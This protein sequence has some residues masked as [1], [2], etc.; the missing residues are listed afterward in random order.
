MCDYE[1]ARAARGPITYSR[2]IYIAL[3]YAMLEE[4]LE[5]GECGDW[6]YDTIHCAIPWE[7]NLKGEVMTYG[8][9]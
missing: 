6:M 4:V 9:F 1:H 3:L 8:R 2:K 5:S 7:S